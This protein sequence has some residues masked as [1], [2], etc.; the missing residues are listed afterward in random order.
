M[1][2]RL[3]LI[4]LIGT[5]SLIFLT[6]C[7]TD[8]GNGA[9]PNTNEPGDPP[10]IE[11]PQ[12]Y[13][14][15]TLAAVLE[16]DGRFITFLD[17]TDSIVGPHGTDPLLTRTS[18]Q[19]RTVWAPTDEAFAA[20]PADLLEKLRSDETTSGELLFHHLF[21]QELYSADFELLPT[22]PT[23]LTIIK[24]NIEVD[25]DQIWYDGARVIETD[26]QAEN[27]VIHVLDA[28]TGI[29]LLTD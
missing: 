14:E 6:G 27:G 8:E 26:I 4:M 22:W 17:L 21:D 5:L 9:E 1:K 10:T 7:G 3:L 19:N 20:L 23:Y 24:V 18:E 28:V 25:G 15:G 13:P 29:E 12:E 2:T 11:R 16:A